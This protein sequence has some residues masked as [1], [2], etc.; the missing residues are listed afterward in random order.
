MWLISLLIYIYLSIPH[1][2]SKQISELGIWDS[3][4]EK[5]TQL[6]MR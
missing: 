4:I 5:D 1:V 6:E 2:N 3:G